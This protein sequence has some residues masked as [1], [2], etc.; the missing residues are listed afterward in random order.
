MR[1]IR[2]PG[3]STDLRLASRLLV[4]LLRLRRVRRPLLVPRTCALEH[5]ISEHSRN[6]QT[7]H[8][9]SHHGRPLGG[10]SSLAC[11]ATG[12]CPQRQIHLIQARTAAGCGLRGLALHRFAEHGHGPVH[13]STDAQA[14][15][16]PAFEHGKQR[17]SIWI[18]T[19]RLKRKGRGRDRQTT[20]GTQS[21]GWKEGG[22]SSVMCGK[23]EHDDAMTGSRPERSAPYIYTKHSAQRR[24]DGFLFWPRA[25][26]FTLFCSPGRSA[27][28]QS[29]LQFYNHSAAPMGHGVWPRQPT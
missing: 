15:C 21:E 27:L 13:A 28:Q 4:P 19:C 2:A 16:G 12:G 17:C 29:A 10:N 22:H 5:A 8:A 7:S 26:R 6:V 23:T 1:P 18:E 9:T 14:S 24:E 25:E 20:T 3:S 11:E